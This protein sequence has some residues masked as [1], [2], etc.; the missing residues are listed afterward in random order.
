[1]ISPTFNSLEWTLEEKIRLLELFIDKDSGVWEDRAN[2]LQEE[3]REKRPSDFFTQT[4][5][6]RELNNIFNKPNPE[7]H[8]FG[9]P[10]HPR[11]KEAAELWLKHFRK[12]LDEWRVRQRQLFMVTMRKQLDLIRRYQHG[13][14]PKQE[15]DALLVEARERDAQRPDKEQYEAKI[16]GQMA[17]AYVGDVKNVRTFTDYFRFLRGVRIPTPARSPSPVIALEEKPKTEIIANSFQGEP[18]GEKEQDEAVTSLCISL[19]KSKEFP[20]P[21]WE[22]E[23]RHNLRPLAEFESV[24]LQTRVAKY[25]EANQNCLLAKSGPEEFKEHK[26]SIRV[27]ECIENG[28]PIIAKGRGKAF[29]TKDVKKAVVGQEESAGTSPKQQR[30]PRALQVAA[31]TPPTE[32]PKTRKRKHEASDETD[33]ELDKPGEKR[34]RRSSK[35]VPETKDVKKAVVGQE[36]SAGTSPKQQRLPRALQVAAATPPTEKPKTRKRKLELSGDEAKD[37]D[38]ESD[39]P[40]EKRSRRSDKIES[41]Q[42]VSSTSF[43][44]PV[45]SQPLISEVAAAAKLRSQ[46]RRA[47]IASATP[48]P[49]VDSVADNRLFLKPGK[50]SSTEIIPKQILLTLWRDIHSHRHAPVFSYPVSEELVRGYHT[51]IK[52]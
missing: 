10:M 9:L 35:T 31:A 6:K 27:V 42:S 21:I 52:K 33:A 36:E 13:K 45:S 24:E 19:D 16:K 49:A 41:D 1:M 47:A 5:V 26:I 4:S 34:L 28:I 20:P 43:S 15:L 39:K 18:V 32:K 25:A 30:L 23:A 29:E 51:A 44:S 46:L 7:H 3:F 37:T 11:G 8:I 48:S 22:S 12:E 14:L 40:T 38:A 17:K 50:L 2:A